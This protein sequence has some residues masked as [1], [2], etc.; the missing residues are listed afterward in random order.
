MLLAS[1]ICFA[2]VSQ[3]RQPPIGAGASG[4]DTF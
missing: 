3:V 2:I 1:L 4:D